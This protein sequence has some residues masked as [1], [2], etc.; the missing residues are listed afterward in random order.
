MSIRDRVM[1]WV[2]GEIVG[3][4]VA[5][6]KKKMRMRMRMEE[7]FKLDK[8]SR[9][10]QNECELCEYLMLSACRV[11]PNWAKKVGRKREKE[12]GWGGRLL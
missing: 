7:T 6:M 5:T 9:C 3:K 2:R 10:R 8:N 11:L 1:C 4:G 12:G